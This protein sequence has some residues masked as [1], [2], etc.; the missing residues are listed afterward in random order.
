M[1][2]VPRTDERSD[3]DHCQEVGEDHPKVVDHEIDDEVDDGEREEDRHRYAI[4]FVFEELQER[5]V[6]R[7]EALILYSWI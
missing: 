4:C 3:G 6:P 7:K 1:M 2:M 5:D